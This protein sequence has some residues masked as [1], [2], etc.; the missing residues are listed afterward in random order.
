MLFPVAL[1]ALLSNVLAQGNVALS[2]NLQNAAGGD[3][4]QELIQSKLT[5][6][7][8]M[9]FELFTFVTNMGTAF[10]E[11]A[12]EKSGDWPNK[13]KNGVKPADEIKRIYAEQKAM[14]ASFRETLVNN[15]AKLT[16]SCKYNFPL[17]DEKAFM[18]LASI[19]TNLG[20][21]AMINLENRL[22]RTDPEV[23]PHISK[24]I[25]VKARHDAFFRTYLDEEVNPSAFA[26]SIPLEWA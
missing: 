26:T 18:S 16:E 24:M 3:L 7:G 20:M 5:L 10:F 25:P 9:E 13:E 8:V 12:V 2:E 4:S 19:I 1:L 21:G 17:K 23:I 15:K 14:T 11:E 22:A 6:E